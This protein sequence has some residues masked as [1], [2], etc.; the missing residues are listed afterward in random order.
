MDG[1]QSGANVPEAAM[2][3]PPGRRD[4]VVWRQSAASGPRTPGPGRPGRESRPGRIRR[5]TRVVGLLT[6]VALFNAARAGRANWPEVGGAVLVVGGMALPGG[7]GGVLILAGALCLL[8]GGVLPPKP[9]PQIAQI[10]PIAPVTPALGPRTI[11][12]R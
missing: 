12:R 1:T 9:R 4:V 7:A 10:T 2:G 11:G 8:G 3:L 5:W 6:A